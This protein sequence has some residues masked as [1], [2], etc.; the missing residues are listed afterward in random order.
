MEGSYGGRAAA[1]PRRAAP[2]SGMAEAPPPSTRSL[3]AAE[4]LSFITISLSDS[5]ELTAMAAEMRAPNDVA[6]RKAGATI[7]G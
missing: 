1:A 4:S 7:R 3:R 5:N 6:G 2:P